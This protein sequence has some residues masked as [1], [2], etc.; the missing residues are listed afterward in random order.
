MKES[1]LK[2]SRVASS[3]RLQGLGAESQLSTWRRATEFGGRTGC[4]KSGWVLYVYCL[5]CLTGRQGLYTGSH[6]VTVIRNSRPGIQ[7]R[8]LRLPSLLPPKGRVTCSQPMD[9]DLGNRVYF[10]EFQ[11]LL[12]E[13]SVFC[14]PVLLPL[15]HLANAAI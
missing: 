11:K 13:N 9:P 8:F 3:P 4:Q 5:I 7:P 2:P 14:I 10:S 15:E 1:Q 6:K 12:A